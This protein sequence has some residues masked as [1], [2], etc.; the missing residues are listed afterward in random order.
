[1]KDQYYIKIIFKHIEIKFDNYGL[2]K[3][4]WN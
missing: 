1:M 3:L 4:I 2:I